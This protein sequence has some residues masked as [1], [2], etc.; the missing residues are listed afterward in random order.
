MDSSMLVCSFFTLKLSQLY[1]I[2]IFLL[3]SIQIC[4]LDTLQVG[5]FIPLT[6]ANFLFFEYSLTFS[7]YRMF[8]YHLV[9][10]LLWLVN[11]PLTQEF[12]VDF[13]GEWI[14]VVGELIAPQVSLLPDTLSRQNRWYIYVYYPTYQPIS[15]IVSVS[16]SLY[17]Y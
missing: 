11:Q 5:S 13:I 8:Q 15:V 17:T 10:S 1:Y 4:P 6:Q 2:L 7:Y 3:K 12:L 9:F 16:I 14:W